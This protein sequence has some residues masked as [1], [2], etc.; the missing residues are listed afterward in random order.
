M[1]PFAPGS[2]SASGGVLIHSPHPSFR[3][4]DVSRDQASHDPL[5]FGDAADGIHHVEA[6]LLD[7]AVVLVEY[8]ALEKPEAFRRIA[9]PAHIHACLIKLQLHATCHEP[10]ER[11][12]DWH[13]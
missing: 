8:F 13:T 6:V 7:D 4:F 12:V 9:A 1:P 11:D 10:I 5:L 2:T 3:C